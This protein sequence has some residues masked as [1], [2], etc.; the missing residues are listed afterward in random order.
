MGSDDIDDAHSPSSP[1]T[2]TTTTTTGKW[3]S[4][5]NCVLYEVLNITS[6]ESGK[7]TERPSLPHVFPI[8]PFWNGVLPLIIQHCYFI[9]PITTA[10]GATPPQ[11]KLHLP[12]NLFVYHG[13][14]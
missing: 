9:I 11:K 1:T 5:C 10:A 12:E 8:S 2:T 14:C 4:Y 7:V 6:Q 13:K 3:S